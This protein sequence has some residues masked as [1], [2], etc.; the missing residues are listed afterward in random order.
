MYARN[1]EWIQANK[2]KFQALDRHDSINRIRET[3]GCGLREAF[4][5][6]NREP[7]TWVSRLLARLQHMEDNKVRYYESAEDQ[8][9]ATLREVYLNTM[10]ESTAIERIALIVNYPKPEGLVTHAKL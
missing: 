2:D 6:W 4:N 1:I 7:S 8:I 10:S 3:F 5:F 9:V